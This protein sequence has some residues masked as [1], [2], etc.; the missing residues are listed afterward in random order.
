PTLI[1]HAASQ[2]VVSSPSNLLLLAAAHYGWALA[3][4]HPGDN[5]V[6]SQVDR[7]SSKP[8]KLLGW[9]TPEQH[10]NVPA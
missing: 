8:Q 4:A 10:L 6:T 5:E 3:S 2:H 9:T 1:F 7:L